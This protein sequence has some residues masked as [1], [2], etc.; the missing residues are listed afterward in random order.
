MHAIFSHR[1]TWSVI[2]FLSLALL[3]ACSKN[4]ADA[5]LVGDGDATDGDQ[6]ADAVKTCPIDMVSETAGQPTEIKWKND[7]EVEY[8]KLHL[9][10]FVTP[11]GVYIDRV[12]T[13]PT[14]S[15]L[16]PDGKTLAVVCTGGKDW[17]LEDRNNQTIRIINTTTQSIA[18]IIEEE[19]LFLSPVFSSDGKRLYA[20]GSIG[21]T[22]FVYDAEND[23][24]KLKTLKIPGVIYGIALTHDGK[25][26]LV[27][28]SH[29]AQVYQIDTASFEIVH[30][31]KTL[32]YPYMIAVAPDDT[33]AYVTNVANAAVSVLD[34]RNRQTL[35]HV[36]VGKNPEGLALYDNLLF[37]ADNDDDTISVIDTATRQVTRK[38]NL[39][40]DET[41]P[42]GRLPVD[43]KISPSDKRLYV[44][45]AGDNSVMAIDLENYR[46]LGEIPT[47][48]YPTDVEV[49]GGKL[50]IANSKGLGTGP[51]F[52]A[53]H[54]E[55]TEDASVGIFFG[56]VNILDVPD[57]AA[58]DDY[59][60]QVHK[61]NREALT[62]FSADCDAWDS[63]IPT[64]IGE[65]STKIR[66]VVFIIKENKTYDVLLGDLKGEQGDKWHDANLA[67]FGEN[68]KIA[69]QY[70]GY[71]ADTRF[72]ITPNTHELARH[73]V[74]MVNFYDNS[75]KSTEGHMWL[76]AG[77]LNDYGE[78]FSLIWQTRGE[79]TFMLPNID[80]LSTPST[81]Q[82][83]GYLLDHGRSVRVYGEYPGTA[84]EL[85]G[86]GWDFACHEYA[87]GISP[88]DDTEKI[89]VFQ[90]E[91]E[92]GVFRDFTYIW[93]PND[94]TLG[95]DADKPHPAYM[96]SDNDEALGRLVDMISKSPH[97]K[98][99]VIFA[100]Q[101][102]PQNT[103]D[104][105]DTHRSIL[106]AAGPYVKRGYT[107]ELAYDMTSLIR[108]MTQI[109][110]VPPISRYE[111]LAQP[112]YD[113][114]TSEPDFSP[115]DFIPQ[116]EKLDDKARWTNPPETELA[117][118]TAR[119]NFESVDRQGG[120]GR[121]LWEVM[122]GPDVPF[123]AHLIADGVEP[124]DEEEEER[125]SPATPQLDEAVA[126]TGKGG[127]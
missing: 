32:S 6:E 77:W 67:F 15:A 3:A 42:P 52:N 122:K 14:G 65:R 35:G 34:L 72:N 95:M 89:K 66:H 101:D 81:G 58:L 4:E 62:Y 85:F 41:D 123:P 117:R 17:T 107:S 84:N 96:V 9:G 93:I 115:Y 39:R 43:L 106:L 50:Y 56:G 59:T 105:I 88:Y 113:I 121:I 37:V 127:N 103:P 27:A 125:R 51:N 61:N 110:G 119:M 97:W 31:Y 47:A 94:H 40:E 53:E 44:T 64:K 45:L 28:V 83:F 82:I 18:K 100:L 98:E 20:G 126:P 109:L 63:P 30:K 71:P 73:Y 48:F 99:T 23:Y 1:F 33:K 60:E 80:H 49:G 24:A 26:L 22:V 124:D 92:Q 25:Y 11:A 78:K 29:K 120:L 90:K 118:R 112:M 55:E 68:T 46:I 70:A 36:A 2:L 38:I 54:P 19:E 5:G 102:D 7:K 10:R 76:T 114:F 104:H 108:T 79:R 8:A 87:V 86:R 57:Q 116:D 111:A 12:G 69:V 75:T 16:S 91:F 21:D 74:D 13:M